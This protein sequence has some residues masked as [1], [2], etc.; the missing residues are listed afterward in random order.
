MS[1]GINASLRSVVRLKYIAEGAEYY[2]KQAMEEAQRAGVE[3]LERETPVLTGY[4]RSTVEGHRNKSAVWF[5]IMGRI[6]GRP[7]GF[8]QEFGWH[9]RGGTF[10][11]GHHMVEHAIEEAKTTFNAYLGGTGRA[12]VISSGDRQY[13]VLEK[14]FGL[15]SGPVGSGAGLFL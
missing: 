13:D 9:D 5:T 11:E 8:A 1:I 14:N 7:Y 3:V 15:S 4:L 6:G 12:P 10:H 2:I